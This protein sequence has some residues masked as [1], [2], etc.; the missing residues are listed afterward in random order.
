MKTIKTALISVW[1]KEGIIDFA[2]FLN[3]QGVKIISTGGT[4]K[5]LE[6]NSIDVISISSIT[7]QKE[8]MDGRVKTLHPKI[9]GGILA[10]RD[11]NSH[12]KD[13][14]EMNSLCI[15]VVVVNLYPVSYTHLTLPTTPYV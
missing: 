7:G 2:K 4:K 12:L 11:N 3:D 13:L 6:E 5:T 15:D 8:V 10:D 14:N 1:D 9:F